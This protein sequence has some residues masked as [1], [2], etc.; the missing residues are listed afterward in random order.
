MSTVNE[1]KTDW[2]LINCVS[3]VQEAGAEDANLPNSFPPQ[4]FIYFLSLI[5]FM[6]QTEITMKRQV[7]I[8][9][10]ENA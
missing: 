6:I 5:S 2:F 10:T 8:E 7:P 9:V 4:I 3:P 1:A